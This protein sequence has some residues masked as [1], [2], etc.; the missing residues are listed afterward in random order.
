MEGDHLAQVGFAQRVAVEREEAPVE[1]A[2][3]EADRATGSERLVLD[4]V[5]ECH[6]VVLVAEDGLDLIGEVAA[7]DDRPLHAVSREVL[8]RVGEQGPIDEREHVLARSVGERSEPR[9]L[10]ADEDDR[11]KTHR[12]GRPMPS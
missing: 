7:R 11:R 4:R 8:E 12:T 6:A 2:P 5:L 3:R 1:L 10:P 9:S